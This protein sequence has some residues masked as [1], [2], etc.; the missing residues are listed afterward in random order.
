MEPT[1]RR[2][3]LAGVSNVYGKA[4][5]HQSELLPRAAK[6]D[7]KDVQ[8]MGSFMYIYIYTMIIDDPLVEKDSMI[9]L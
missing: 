7:K 4:G 2:S 9:P 5:P 1:K 6:A 3:R 8:I